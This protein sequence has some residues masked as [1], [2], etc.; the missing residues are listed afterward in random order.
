[1]KIKWE[2]L[3]KWMQK[4]KDWNMKSY[5]LREND[6]AYRILPPSTKMMVD[7]IGAPWAGAT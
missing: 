7:P 4:M 2:K 1:M 3:K 6:N 5:L